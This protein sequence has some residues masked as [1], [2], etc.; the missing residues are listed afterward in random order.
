M[1]L[2]K[3]LRKN[4]GKIMA[5]VVVVLMISFGAGQFLRHL[6]QRRQ[7]GLTQVMGHYDQDRT[8]TREDLMQS[9]Q[10]LELLGAIGSDMILRSMGSQQVPNLRA[11]LLA[12]L[13]FPGGRGSA[14]IMQ[15]LRQIIASQGYPISP[16]QLEAIYAGQLGPDFYWHLL[17]AEAERAGVQ[18][19]HEFAQAQL[20]QILPQIPMMG[21]ATY[22]QIIYAMMTQHGVSEQQILSAFS[23]LLSVVQYADMVSSSQD[24][25]NAELLHKAVAENEYMD[26]EYVQLSAE[27]FIDAVEEPSREQIEAHFEKYK[28]TAAGTI[29]EDNPYGFGYL[30]P[31]RVQLEYMMFYLDDVLETIDRPTAEQ[32]EQHYQANRQQYTETV[33]VDPDDPN[34]PQRQ[35]VKSYAEVAGQIRR[36]MTESRK[37]GEALNIIQRF[38]DKI[39]ETEEQAIAEAD[40]SI[41]KTYEAASEQIS[42]DVRLYTGKTGLLTA[43]DISRDDKLGMMF[44]QDQGRAAVGIASKAF[45]IDAL[46]YTAGLFDADAPEIFQSFGPVRDGRDALMGL[47]RVIDVAGKEAPESV[48][49]SFSQASVVLNEADEN[50]YSVREAVV[51]DLKKL[52]AME[53]LESK[54]DELLALV[55]EHGWD[56]AVEKFNQ[57]YELEENPVRVQTQDDINRLSESMVRRLE[58]Q[59]Q[60]DPTAEFFLRNIKEQKMWRDKLYSL[61][62]AGESRPA[63]LPMIAEFKPHKSWYVFKDVELERL[64]EGQYEQLKAFQA[65]REQLTGA[66]AMAVVHFNP[67]NIE[68]RMGFELVRREQQEPEDFEDLDEI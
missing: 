43:A 17:T 27:N 31:E 34:S 48:D 65:Y 58:I 66:Q 49:V 18:V 50:I 42:G 29:T 47:M 61:I 51:N 4:K 21:G 26:I 44:L 12:E 60:G 68:Q 55:S 45:A 7:M 15:H 22:E 25:T 8:I 1:H 67:S 37:Q 2:M 35:R 33:P 52:A 56:E 3:F 63:E 11:I 10:E 6:G 62:P 5:I 16:A 24:L 28:N 64:T 20:Q 54:A 40:A 13:I 14:Q 39:Q 19:D 32:M 46:G 36:E 9:G 30:L 38:R 59:N 23:R 57:Q 41:L 53:M